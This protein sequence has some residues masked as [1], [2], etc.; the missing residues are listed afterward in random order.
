MKQIRRWL[1][2]L[3]GF[4]TP[5]GGLSWSPI[6]EKRDDIPTFDGTILLTSN[7][8]DEFISFLDQNAGRIVFLK[9]II[10]A[11]VA[12]RKQIEFVETE[13]LDLDSLTSGSFSGHTFPLQN[14]L[15]RITYVVFHFTANHVL[16]VSFG[17]TGTVMVPLNGFF[18]VS[19]T[20]HGGPSTVFHLKE[21]DAPLEA[22]LERLNSATDH[23]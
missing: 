13:N 20:L 17:G 15:G 8:N 4:S 18:E 14:D 6:P 23:S 2:Q 9:T 1:R 11:C 5:L 12:T 3:T 16:N 22:R 7:G 10:D 19:P 21:I